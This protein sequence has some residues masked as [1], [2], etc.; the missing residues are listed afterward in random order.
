MLDAG[1]PLCRTESTSVHLP[2]NEEQRAI[3]AYVT[4]VTSRIITAWAELV[5]AEF[6]VPVENLRRAKKIRRYPTDLLLNSLAIAYISISCVRHFANHRR[7]HYQHYYNRRVPN[8]ITSS[9]AY[10]RLPCVLR[11]WLSKRYTL[12]TVGKRP[13]LNTNLL[14]NSLE[15]TYPSVCRVTPPF[16]NCRRR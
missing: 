15:I 16:T 3:M 5:L 10:R 8:A 11:H 7:C 9:W 2:N 13:R 4:Y 12:S 14:S 6:R 1:C